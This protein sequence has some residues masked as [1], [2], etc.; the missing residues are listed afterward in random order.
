MKTTIK[1]HTSGESEVN[2]YKTG[3]FIDDNEIMYSKCKYN[4]DFYYKNM[5]IAN[6]QYAT[7]RDTKKAIE[8]L[9]SKIKHYCFLYNETEL[10]F[11]NKFI[12]EYYETN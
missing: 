3:Y 12:K 9:K 10:E 7:E 5:Y 1:H 2:L 4:Y 8:Y 6:V 11:V